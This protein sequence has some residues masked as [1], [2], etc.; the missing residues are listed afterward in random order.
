MTALRQEKGGKK[1]P[2]KK[3]TENQMFEKQHSAPPKPPKVGPN[4]I[5]KE[6]GVPK[7]FRRGP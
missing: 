4:L 1:G 7:R 3:E 2:D 6:D 5:F